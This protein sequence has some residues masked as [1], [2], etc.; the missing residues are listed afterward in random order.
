MT[1]LVA[2]KAPLHRRA[3]ARAARLDMKLQELVEQALEGFLKAK[4]KVQ[5]NH[6]GLGES[7][8]AVATR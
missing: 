8:P 1:K 6:A 3:K 4:P 7:G 2:I 5:P